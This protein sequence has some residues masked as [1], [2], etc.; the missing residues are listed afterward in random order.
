[1]YIWQVVDTENGTVTVAPTS[2]VAIGNGSLSSFTLELKKVKQSD[3]GT[4]ECVATLAGSKD[5][6]IKVINVT[7]SKHLTIYLFKQM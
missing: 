3:E 4:Y 6:T 2:A 7:I 5:I 1:M